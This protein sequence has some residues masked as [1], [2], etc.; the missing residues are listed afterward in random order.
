[1]CFCTSDHCKHI[2]YSN[3][4][5]LFCYREKDILVRLNEKNT[6]GSREYDHEGILELF[7]TLPTLKTISMVTIKHIANLF[8]K[9]YNSSL[10][11]S[12]HHWNFIWFV[13]IIWIIW[14]LYTG[15]FSLSFYFRP[16]RP[17]CKY[18]NLRLCKENTVD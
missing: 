5:Y 8:F 15:K 1:M 10:S 17:R 13:L 7:R 18:T 4:S 12:I 2:H 14:I 9:F 16:F 6:L 3:N 11:H